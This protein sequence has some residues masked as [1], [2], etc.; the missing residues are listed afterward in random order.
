MSDDLA[1]G[2]Q[3]ED[4]QGAPGTSD[5]PYAEY[6]NRIPEELRS[7][8]E[9]VFKEWDSNV[10]RKFQEA[11]EFRKQWEP[12]APLGV[13]E[14]SP[15]E[16]AWALQFRQAAVHNPDAV[17]QWYDEY[18]NA[19]GLAAAKQQLEQAT[20]STAEE[21]GFTDPTVSALEQQLKPIQDQLQA[22]NRWREQQ[23]ETHRLAEAER[24][25]HAQMDELKGK[26]PDDWNQGAV[27][28]LVAQYI[29]T[30]PQH[31]VQRAFAD[32]QA[33]KAQIEKDTLQ[34]KADQ[35]PPAESGGTVNAAPE[36][37][38]T[39]AEANRAA[40]ERLRQNRAA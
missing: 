8:V 5:A 15:D 2:T 19:H 6:L 14:L 23:E 35:P 31:A 21:F 26:H 22:M 16:V 29:E 1:A 4:G 27:E 33:I 12:Y 25:V 28:R 24:Y 11:A 36:E 18:A 3:P 40:L 10:G 13:T 32:W 17:Q 7:Q 34:S 38:R 20:G 9:P 39:M 30:D 37:F